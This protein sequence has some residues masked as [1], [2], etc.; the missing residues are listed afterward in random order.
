MTDRSNI[1]YLFDRPKEPLFVAKGNDNVSF[2][3]PSEYLV[4]IDVFVK[5]FIH[6]LNFYKYCLSGQ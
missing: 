5:T 4:S 6:S 3:V 2:N 1:L